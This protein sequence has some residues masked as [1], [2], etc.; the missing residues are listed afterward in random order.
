MVKLS[1]VATWFQTREAYDFF[2]SLSFLETVVVAVENAGRLK[3][4]VVGYVQKDGG[5]L[6]K[7][8]SRRAIIFGGPLLANDITEQ[9]LG[10]LLLSLKDYLRQKAIYIETRNYN[11]YSIWQSVFEGYGFYYEPHYDIH[12]DTS[13]MPTVD[14]NLGK[15]RKR[16]IRVSFRDGATI[17]EHPTIEQVKACYSILKDLYQTKVKTP[18]FPLEFFEKLFELSSS[19]VLLVEYEGKIIGGTF[20]VGLQGK[21]LYEMYACG[22]DGLYKNIHPSELATYAGLKWAA[23]NGFVKFDMMG[24]GKPGDGGYGVRDFKLKF[25]GQLLDQGRFICVCNRML[26]DV[27][28]F[29]VKMLKKL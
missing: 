15:S 8:F 17:V 27:G 19:V 14:E 24:A 12:V 4:V 21:A 26:F 11:D 29:G 5:W 18:L 1:P 23:E 2:K 16:D 7:Y 6:E 25:G 3:G 10:L 28:R 22:Q 9:E 13:T 20:C